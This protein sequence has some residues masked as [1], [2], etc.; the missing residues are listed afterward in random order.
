MINIDIGNKQELE[1]KISKLNSLLKRA[2]GFNR[3]LIKE[4]IKTYEFCL[5][6]LEKW[7]LKLI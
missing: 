3:T 6:D 4:N 7:L 1:N 5:G 2:T